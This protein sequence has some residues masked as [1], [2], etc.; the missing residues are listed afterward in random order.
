MRKKYKNLIL[1]VIVSFFSFTT[2]ARALNEGECQ[3]L[4]GPNTMDMLRMI[5]TIIRWAVPACL[6]I[7]SSIDFMN[8]VVKSSPAQEL[9]KAW[10]KV[11]TR[12]AIGILIFVTPNLLNFILAIIDSS[13]CGI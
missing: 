8:A 5:M 11:L 9:T 2:I 12:L 7:Y 4:L 13:T 6:V 1:L 3:E 10:K